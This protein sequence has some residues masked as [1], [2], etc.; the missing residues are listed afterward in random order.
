MPDLVLLDIMMPKQDGV[1]TCRQI[2]DTPELASCFVI[3]LTNGGFEGKTYWL[4]SQ[5]Y[6]YGVELF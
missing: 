2:R 5:S 4:I 6:F 3:F 1:E